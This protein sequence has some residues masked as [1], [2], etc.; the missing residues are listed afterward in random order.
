MLDWLIY[1]AAGKLAIF[2]FQS[3]PLPTRLEENP[4]IGKLH[5][6]GLCFGVY[7][8]TFLAWFLKI[9]A[10]SDLG[11]WYVPIVSEIITGMISSFVVHLFSLGWNAQFNQAIIL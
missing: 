6:C 1:L 8:F 5:R 2:F 3:F 7:A 11:F 4:F 9:D 10:L